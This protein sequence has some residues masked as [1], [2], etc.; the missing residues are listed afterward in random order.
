M[1]CRPDTEE[2]DPVR[3]YFCLHWV[4]WGMHRQANLQPTYGT[5]A[6]SSNTTF[7]KMVWKYRGRIPKLDQGGGKGYKGIYYSDL[8]NFQRLHC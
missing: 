7:A 8:H 4:Y 1:I 5:F 3:S 2:E 6:K